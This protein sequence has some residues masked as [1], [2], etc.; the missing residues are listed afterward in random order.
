VRISTVWIRRKDGEWNEAPEIQLAWTEHDIDN[1]YEG[2]VEALDKALS[3]VGDDLRDYRIIDIEVPWQ[4]IVDAFGDPVVEA[5][6][7]EVVQEDEA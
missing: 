5:T 1:W 6:G 7:V 3:A 4:S 2:W